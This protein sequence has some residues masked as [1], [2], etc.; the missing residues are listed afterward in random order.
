MTRTDPAELEKRYRGFCV[1]IDE[2]HAQ[3]FPFAVSWTDSEGRYFPL[4]KETRFKTRKAAFETA[5]RLIDAQYEAESQR[6]CIHFNRGA[7]P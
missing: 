1:E 5:C 3:P 4:P 6:A 2:D 7:K